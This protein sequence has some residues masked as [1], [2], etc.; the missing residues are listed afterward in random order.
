MLVLGFEHA[1]AGSEVHTPKHCDIISRIGSKL[2]REE[3]D[4]SHPLTQ[5]L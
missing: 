2:H 3:G 1:M 4:M 5:Q